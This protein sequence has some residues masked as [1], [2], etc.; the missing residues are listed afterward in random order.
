MIEALIGMG[1][2]VLGAILAALYFRPLK[3]ENTR[4]RSTIETLNAAKQTLESASIT[5][6]EDIARLR[7]EKDAME[8]RMA[9][10][11]AD[12][13]TLMGRFENLSNKIFEAKGEKFKQQS[14]EGLNLLL[15]PLKEKIGEFQKKIDE[16]FGEQAK[17]QRSLKDQIKNIVETNNRMTLQAESLANALKGDSKVQGNWGEYI[18]EKLLED[19]GLRRDEDYTLQGA[20]MNLVDQDNRQQRPDVIINLPE[21]R[22]I[23]IDSKLTLT[24]YERFFSETDE[25]QRPVHLTAFKKSVRDRVLELEKTG[26]QDNEKLGTPDFV[27]MFV[28]IEGA[29]ALAVQND[30]ALHEYAWAKRVVIVSPTTLFATMRTIA[31]IWR[32]ER[33]NRNVQEI[34]RQGGAL[35]DKIA[36]LLSDMSSLGGQLQKVG[37]VYENAMK[38]L[39]TGQGNIVSRIE[40]LKTLGAKTTKSL[41][42]DFFA[43]GPEAAEIAALLEEPEEILDRE[44][45]T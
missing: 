45:G 41:P 19:S 21:N 29:Y 37:A 9:Q 22:H 7:A 43:E 3:A 16:S 39:S 10:Q 8:Q 33:Q 5:L 32:L 38:K 17:E 27:L 1:G 14:Q 44:T 28:P 26:Y 42:K 25:T 31:S 40:K 6:R 15:T 2:L 13:E 36:G 30:P 18:L 35:Y 4:H 20:G 23:I 11:K 24:S 34:A 12:E